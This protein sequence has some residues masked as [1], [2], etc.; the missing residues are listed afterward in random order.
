MSKSKKNEKNPEQKKASLIAVFDPNSPGSGD[1]IYGLP[2]DLD[3][4][5][6][7]LLPAPW[8]VT[9]SYQSGTAKGP[10]AM[11]DASFQVDLYD[12]EY[13]ELWKA[14]IWMAPVPE[15]WKKNSKRY[16]KQARDYM[17]WLLEGKP[18]ND[19][20][21]YE[22]V[23]QQIHQGCQEFNAW[24][25]AQVAEYRTSGKLVILLGGDHS[26][27]LG[28]YQALNDEQQPFGILH[29]DAHADLRPAYEDFEFSHASIMYNALKL[30]ALTKLVQVG[31]RDYCDQEARLISDSDKKIVLFSDQELKNKLFNGETWAKLCAAIIK[32]LPD[33]VF[34]SIDIDH[35]DPALCPNTGTPVPGGNSFEMTTYLL[36]QLALSGKQVIGADLVEVAPGDDEWDANVGARLLYKLIGCL[37]KS[38]GLLTS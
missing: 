24:V 12:V 1:Q 18:G 19:Q 25:R 17:E 30:P 16:R 5:K 37:A 20:D 32:E 14:G 8:E 38:N 33:R 23:L 27:P 26:T 3:T 13:P 29:L 9:V 36:S 34:I 2:F 22:K 31:I 10:D 4:A 15:K 6:I 21:Y 28:Y 35:F 11:L 7:V